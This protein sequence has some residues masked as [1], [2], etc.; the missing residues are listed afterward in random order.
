MIL[1]FLFILIILYFIVKFIKSKCIHCYID[2]K[3]LMAFFGSGGH[4]SEM[5]CMMNQILSKRKIIDTY[6]FVYNRGDEPTEIILKNLEIKYSKYKII[7]MPV[8]RARKVSQSL[9]TSCFTTMYSFCEILFKVF[10]VH[11]T[12]IISNGPGTG[13]IL[14]L[15]G[16]LRNFFYATARIKLPKTKLLYIESICRTKTLSKS[17]YIAYT[18]VNE[19]VVQWK[20]LKLAYPK[21]NYLGFLF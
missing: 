1:Q 9:I 4:T 3:S 6:Y 8:S 10:F 2:Q 12:I 11:S 19:F 15:I 13:L 7:L 5:M 21:S 16:K 18:F 14:L 20:N 17:G